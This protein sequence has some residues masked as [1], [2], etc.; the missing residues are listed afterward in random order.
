MQTKCF[1]YLFFIVIILYSININ[2]QTHGQIFNKVEADNLYGQ[3]TFSISIETQSLISLLNKT[4]NYLLFTIY[5][6]KAYFFNN[7]RIC[8]SEDYTSFESSYVLRSFSLSMINELI[9]KGRNTFTLIEKR[10]DIFT[11]TNGEYT[12]ET[13]YPCPPY[14]TD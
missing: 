8:I 12:L 13:S 6:N 7:K 9:N 3:V 2:C 11:F 1:L 4:N 10:N 14:C 5:N